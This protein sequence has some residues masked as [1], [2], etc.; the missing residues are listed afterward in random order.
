MLVRRAD[1]C[2]SNTEAG[3]QYLIEILGARPQSVCAR[4]YLV[5]TPELLD[6]DS[7]QPAQRLSSSERPLFLYVGALTAR[8]GVREL[9]QACGRLRAMGTTRSAS[10]LP[11]VADRRGRR[12][13]VLLSA[14]SCRPGAGSEPGVGW[15]VAGAMSAYHDVWVLTWALNRPH[16]EPALDSQRSDRLRFSYY[17]LPGWRLLRKLGARLPHLHYYLWQLGAYRR[18]RALQRE[19]GFDLAQHVTYVKYSTPSLLCLLPIPFLWGPVGG[20]ETAPPSFERD[21]P[22]RGR[23]YELRQ[24][25]VL[26]HPSLHDSGGWSLLE[27]MA[28][29]CP[30]ICLDLGG[31][32]VRVDDESG[33]RVAARN[34]EQ[35]VDDIAAALV[36]L[37]RDPAL[38]RRMGE[39]GRVRVGEHFSWQKRAAVLDETYRRIAA[40]VIE[41]SDG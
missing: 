19:I 3:R 30:V 12:L 26:L 25:H 9:L 20:G 31:S 36:R 6:L 8:K 37:G 40:S 32:A 7:S 29:A 4:P 21:F 17:E 38:R 27:A 1:A 34:P 28:A 10:V 13:K 14:Y 5:P 41:R 23:V 16:I 39:A 24:S 2:F 35:V 22:L 15:N 18:M 11:P 33:I